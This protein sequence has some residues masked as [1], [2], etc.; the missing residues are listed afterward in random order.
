V[1]PGENDRNTTFND[2]LTSGNYT[3][4]KHIK[5]VTDRQQQRSSKGLDTHD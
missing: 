4:G 5:E 3:H 2:K 1:K